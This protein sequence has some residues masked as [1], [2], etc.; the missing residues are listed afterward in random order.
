MP[1]WVAIACMH[2]STTPIRN[3]CAGVGKIHDPHD[4]LSLDAFCFTWHTQVFVIPIEEE[5]ISLFNELSRFGR[6]PV[7]NLSFSSVC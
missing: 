2:A 5:G 1:K 4:L 7:S 6:V 3:F